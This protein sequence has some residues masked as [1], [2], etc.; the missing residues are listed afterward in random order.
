M[1]HLYAGDDRGPVAPA[2][3]MRNLEVLL[4]PGTQKRAA[5]ERFVAGRQNPQLPGNRRWLTPEQFAARFGARRS[6]A[7]QVAA[8]L[9]AAGMKDIRIARGRL[10]ISFSGTAA[11]VEAAFQTSIHRFAVGGRMHFANVAPASLPASLRRYVCGVMGLDDFNPVPQLVRTPAS[12]YAAGNGTNDLGPA[13]LAAIYD[14]GSLFDRG[15]TGSGVTV[16]ILGQTPIGLDDYRAY[17]ARFGLPAN[18]FHS[19]EVP[20]S[21]SGTNATLDLEEATLDLEAVGA[22]ARSASILYVWGTTVQV[23]AAYAIDN[24]LAQ[25]ISFSYAGCEIPG[26]Q[27]Y[28]MLAL[29]A[30]AEGITWVSASGDSGAAGCD[31]AGSASATEGL[32]VMVPASAPGIT[33]VGGTAFA[34][35]SSAQYW[36]SG[37]NAQDGSALGY[38]PETGWST[39]GEVLAGGGGVSNI[40]PKPGYQS[41]VAPA[42]T[43]GRMVPDVALAASPETVPYLIVYN[44]SPLLVGGTS[45]A[46]PVFAGIAV[47]INN[48][49]VAGGTLAAPGLGS[50]N[51]VLYLLAER[52][53]N[54]F[55]DVT[56]GSNDVP[57]TAGTKD[58]AD[59]TLGY[60][61]QP[62]Y[63]L[64][65]GLGS[66]DAYAL[67]SNWTNATF[68]SSFTALTA[69]AS[70]DQ[71]EQ[72][73]TLN[74]TVTS[75]GS[76][77]AG[78]PVEFYYTNP[79]SQPSQTMLGSAITGASGAATLVSSL[80]P[81]GPNAVT[82]ASGGTT[83]VA[84][85][86]ES[87][88][89][90]VSVS[91]F[92]TSVA[93]TPSGGPY[94]AGQSVIFSIQ[95]SGPPGTVLAGPSSQDWH[96]LPGSVSL[97]SGAGALIASASLAY[98]GSATLVTN[99]LAAGGNTF[100]ASYS[101]N[102]YA[103]PSQSAPLTLTASAGN[104]ASTATTIS[105]SAAQVTLGNSITLTALVS[106]ASGSTTPTGS[107]TFFSNSSSLAT[108]ALNSGGT[109][110]YTFAPASQEEL[111]LTALYS[112]SSAFS[113]SVS[114]PLTI[115]VAP[116]APDFMISGPS[117]VTM[118]AGSHASAV[119]SVTALNGFSG[120][121]QLRCSG[122]PSGDTCSLPASI[123][124]SGTTPF[125]VTIAAAG[126]SLAACL[127]LGMILLLLAGKRRT[128]GLA[129]LVITAPVLL[130]G[131]SS[132]ITR[133]SDST[134]LW[135]QTFTVTVTAASGS[136]AHQC[137]F[138]VTVAP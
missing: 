68:A 33:A 64:A 90:V 60:T 127:P 111:A 36:S 135:A 17:R 57:C 87:N 106:P 45:A 40:F 122:L 81:I 24:Q 85:S 118:T 8:W 105:A 94:R 5:L 41:D 126:A 114:S 48:Y 50:I 9:A 77:L 138:T 2:M 49:L 3:P 26:G 7:A 80:M 38:V 22:V 72:S 137:A 46:T 107:V 95:V 73:V 58:C 89:V 42:V 115:T 23:A 130:S 91:P 132:S 47:L 63:D 71:A 27:F 28:Q 124:P 54:V 110:A 25:I 128:A 4:D 100:Y 97:Y 78:S 30:A 51:S 53:P 131:C 19:I 88:S 16:A 86:A 32:N 125:T 103:G 129:L 52:A 61:A 96:Y 109:A 37:N 121:I 123:T 43:T 117:S 67:A 14:I 76:P 99:A 92:P 59:G 75:G 136:L 1:A 113:S 66:V 21:G 112:G 20:S 101:G 55:H 133:S 10:F 34:D 108:V 134:G 119:L 84:A 62:G 12:Q 35:G 70:T 98:D 79:Q 93:I 31:A 102:Y 56:T 29:Q 69:A 13:D 11:Q 39:P 120:T 18:D 104:I 65:T 44:G 15:I 82:A 83:T 6:D 74:A 116:P